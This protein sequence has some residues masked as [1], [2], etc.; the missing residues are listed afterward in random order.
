MTPDLK[1]RRDRYFLPLADAL[2]PHGFELEKSTGHFVSKTEL[3]SA[4][5]WPIF[6]D[7]KPGWRIGLDI[8]VRVDQVENALG[9]HSGILPQAST[10]RS[11]TVGASVQSVGGCDRQTIE[12]IVKPGDDPEDAVPTAVDAFVACAQPWSAGFSDLQDFD[13]FLNTDPF[14]PRSGAGLPVLR[15]ARGLIV[16]RLVGRPDYEALRQSYVDDLASRDGGFYLGSFM[17]LVEHLQRSSEGA[18]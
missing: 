2:R 3:G 12:A 5:F 10:K 18:I 1:A 6:M 15:F 9:R 8:G 13:T 17:P 14:K 11:C 4:R 7:A 16:A